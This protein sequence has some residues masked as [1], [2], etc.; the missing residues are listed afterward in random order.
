MATV[1]TKTTITLL[2]IFTLVLSTSVMKGGRK[3]AAA[4]LKCSSVYGTEVGDT[5]SSVAVNSALTLNDFLA[6]NPNINCAKIFVG[7]WLCIAA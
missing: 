1:S 6:I 3:L 2:L 4:K 5:C 7:Q